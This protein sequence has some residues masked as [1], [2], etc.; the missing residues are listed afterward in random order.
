[1]AEQLDAFLLELECEFD[2]QRAFLEDR[3]DEYPD[4]T[5]AVK[6]VIIE[7]LKM[8]FEEHCDRIMIDPIAIDDLRINPVR[9]PASFRRPD[10]RDV[11]YPPRPILNRHQ[12]WA[13]EARAYLHTLL[14][15]V[16]TYNP[17]AG[18][19]PPHYVKP[20]GA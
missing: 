18:E 7:R 10:L 19:A 5:Q 17:I 15:R 9:M 12:R 20:A 14:P 11:Q 1:M 16:P 4:R 6:D 2:S 8:L 3:N 13:A